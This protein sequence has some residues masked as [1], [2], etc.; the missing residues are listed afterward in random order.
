MIMMKKDIYAI[1]IFSL[2]LSGCTS[3]YM[4][5]EDRFDITEYETEIQTKELSD[6]PVYVKV[7]SDM[8]FLPY[9]IRQLA[10][11]FYDVSPEELESMIIREESWDLDYIDTEYQ[12]NH[13]SL[14]LNAY[15]DGF[16]YSMFDGASQYNRI[17]RQFES[18]TAVSFAALTQRYPREE[19][20][21]LPSAEAVTI[22]EAAVRKMGLPIVLEEVIACDAEALNKLQ[23][24]PNN[25]DVYKG[26]G[27]TAD[28]IKKWEKE[29]E[30]YALFYRP[31]ERGGFSVHSLFF[32][33]NYVVFFCRADGKIVFVDGACPLFDLSAGEGE[34]VKAISEKQAWELARQYAGKNTVISVT[35]GYCTEGGTADSR[36]LA[37]C[38]IV[39]YEAIG[40]GR[41]VI[42]Y[43]YIDATTGAKINPLM[44][45]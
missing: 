28:E 43:F 31:A 6:E 10:P 35:L 20:E 25:I 40:G 13:T 42:D 34:E 37:P 8:K 36:F 14:I 26:I 29:Q 21:M 27:S 2:F 9:K 19:L 39:G 7:Y 38:W 22:C 24:N 30:F 4:S 18:A 45:S 11:A 3:I 15:K 1:A 23:E 32:T 44:Y 5:T 16:S 41:A 17:I 33:G 12:G